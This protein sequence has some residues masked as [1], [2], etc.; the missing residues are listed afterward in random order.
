MPNDKLCYSHY[1]DLELFGLI[2]Q[3]NLTA[4]EELYHRYW[5]T[6]TDSVYKRL[7]SRQ[8]AEDLVQD[9]FIDIF[10]KRNIIEF[11]VSVKAY[12]HQAIKYKVL[13]E[14][15]SD[16]IKNN[17]TKSLFFSPTSKNDFANHLE[18][19]DLRLKITEVMNQLPEK[20]KK[21]FLLSR[22]ENLSN[23]EISSNMKISVSTVE[24]HIGK[25]LKMFRD[26]LKDYSS[27]NTIMN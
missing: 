19:K 24:K 12:L 5:G 7:Q 22:M 23:K 25:A 17:Y 3:E 20:C 16:N 8:K 4:F 21:A 13:N 6:L 11:K 9:L 1:S 18:A 26:S 27:F 15:R 14:F 10:Q 2:K